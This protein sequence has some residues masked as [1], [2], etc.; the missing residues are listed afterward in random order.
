M[1]YSGWT[2]ITN[3]LIWWP[4][5]ILYLKEVSAKRGGV[6]GMLLGE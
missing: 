3:D 5:F 4:A 1:W 6:V 2:I